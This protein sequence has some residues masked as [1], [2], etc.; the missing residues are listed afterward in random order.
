MINGSKV[1]VLRE[2]AR[3]LKT[4]RTFFENEGVMEVE[5]PALSSFA[6]HD[7]YIKNFKTQ[8]F[9]KDMF[10]HSSPEFAMKRL[11]VEGS[12]SIFQVCKSFRYESFGTKH[13][14]E[15]SM[16]EWYMI[17]WDLNQLMD[18]VSILMEVI[19]DCG[20]CER[21]SYRELFENYFGI[22]PHSVSQEKLKE[23]AQSYSELSQAEFSKDDYQN[24]LLS[25]LEAKIGMDR[26]VILYDFPESQSALAEVRQADCANYKVAKRFELYFKGIELANA[27][28]E[29][30]CVD[31]LKSLVERDNQIREKNEDNYVE[32]DSYFLSAMEKGLP[33]SAG[34][35]LGIDR[36]LM[37]LLGKNSIDEV[38]SFSV[39]EV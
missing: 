31:S 19:F 7:P 38:L 18:Q 11:L 8:Y 4:I 29:L 34:I 1:Q 35:A 16:L 22:N 37:L 9:G 13:N 15:F 5:T 6:N 17:D 14:P 39:E 28:Q 2:R 36:V 21:I 23:I 33:K 24:F 20:A 32:I 3:L 27:Y 30:Q 25:H 12:G 26:P 10:L